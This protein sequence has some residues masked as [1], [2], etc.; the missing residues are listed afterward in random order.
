[1]HSPMRS[2]CSAL[3]RL[4]PRETSSIWTRGGTQVNLMDPESKYMH[5]HPNHGFL[6][7][8]PAK[9]FP[10]TPSYNFS[11]FGPDA[12]IYCFLLSTLKSPLCFQVCNDLATLSFASVSVHFFKMKYC[13]LLFD[14]DGLSFFF[15]FNCS[16]KKYRNMFVGFD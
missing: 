16:N 15:H 5:V 12:L 4:M 14:T 2:C 3:E 7:W 11:C 1:M 8:E 13:L 6:L 9:N 10:G